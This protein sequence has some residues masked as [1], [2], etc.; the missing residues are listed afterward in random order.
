[1]SEHAHEYERGVHMA[2]AFGIGGRIWAC[3]ICGTP[4]PERDDAER[5]L[6]LLNNASV[7][8]AD[9]AFV[10]GL[11]TRKVQS[12]LQSLR[13]EGKPILSDGD[14]IRLAQT[15]DE[16][17]ACADAL[18]RRLVTQY[19]TLRAMR[20]TARAMRVRE[21]AAARA[22]LWDFWHGEGAAS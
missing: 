5:V 7:P 2:E 9:L 20:A 8:Q 11:S 3:A 14:G 13:L 17:R 22:T 21:D 6:R 1:M 16:A 19:R 10:L 18:R 12:A 15:A 4:K